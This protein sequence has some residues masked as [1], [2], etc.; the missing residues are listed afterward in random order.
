MNI[1]LIYVRYVVDTL[2]AFDN[3]QDSLNF[4]ILK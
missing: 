1:I 3:E 4:L 2:V